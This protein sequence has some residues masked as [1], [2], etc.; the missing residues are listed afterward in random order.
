[1]FGERIQGLLK[2]KNLLSQAVYFPLIES[3]ARKKDW[4]RLIDLLY[5]NQ[6]FVLQIPGLLE[7][8]VSVTQRQNIADSRPLIQIWKT[9][10]SIFDPPSFL[11]HTKAM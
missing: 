11:H 10:P 4:G 2:E 8:M 5:P 1:M 3:G 6:P 7:F 9:F